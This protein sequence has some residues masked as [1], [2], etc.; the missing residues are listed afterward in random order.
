MEDLKIGIL[1]CARIAEQ[2][3]LTPVSAMPDTAVVHVGARDANRAAEFAAQH[4]IARSSGGY[5]DVIADPDVNLVYNPLPNSLH[6]EW[7]IRAL[8]AGKAVLCEKPLT[9]NE[10]E[11]RQLVDVARATGSPLIVAVHYRYHPLARRMAEVAQS[12]IL[13]KFLALQIT[14]N[15]PKGIVPDDDIRFDYDLAGG[16]GMD[17]GSY[18]LDM[19]QLVTGEEAHVDLARAKML[20]SEIDYAMDV[21]LTYPGG[22][23]GVLSFSLQHPNPDFDISLRLEGSDGTLEV[24]NPVVP[25]F[26]FYPHE[27]VVTQ[28]EQRT[29]EH[30]SSA[31]TYEFQLREVA[32]VVL[33][34]APIL[35]T[36]EASA[37]TMKG[38]DAMYRA[39]GLKVRGR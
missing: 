34:G 20:R 18:C 24:T 1:G 30:F 7:T 38:V 4:H 37:T 26:S 33:K 17:V 14:F 31:S 13:G 22:C 32:Q 6:F 27:L 12:G 15:V 3:I 11:A 9:S 5:E 19:G 36:A 21:E 28:G 29:I 25:H 35:T 23:K 8:E 39:A 2:A 10:A 16:A